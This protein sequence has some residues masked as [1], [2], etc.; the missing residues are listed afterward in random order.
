[1]TGMFH[2]QYLVSGDAY[3]AR[4]AV[5]GALT[6]QDFEIE[7]RSADDWQATHGTRPSFLQRMVSNAHEPVALHV[8]FEQQG[9]ELAIDLRRPAFSVSGGMTRDPSQMAYFDKTYR[10]AAAAVHEQLTAAGILVSSR[11]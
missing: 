1:M 9:G 7:E 8:T 3:E 6:Q 10:A 5:R 11:E 4:A 2:W